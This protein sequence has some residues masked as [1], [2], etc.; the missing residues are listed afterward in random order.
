MK[1][2]SK[3]AGIGVMA[4]SVAVLPA[5][6][7]SVAQTNNNPANEAIQE[8]QQ[9]NQPNLDTTPLQET[10]GQADNWGW[11]GLI[12]LVGL[13]NLF[14]KPSRATAYREPDMAGRSS[15]DRY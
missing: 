8:T 13:F 14:R 9:N 11:L 4:L 2:L 7:P 3:L 12:G 10:E 1:R 15:S 6:L 5:T